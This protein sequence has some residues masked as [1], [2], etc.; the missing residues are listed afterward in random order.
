MA[1]CTVDSVLA[2]RHVDLEVILIDDGSSTPLVV[3]DDPRL[4][5][6][7]HA[8]PRGVSAARNSGIAAANGEWIAFCDDDDVWAPDKLAAQLSAATAIGASWVYAGEVAVDERLRILGGRPPLAPEQV[9]ALLPRFNAVPGSASS[10]MVRADLL[11]HVGDFDPA[12][13]RTEDWDMWLRLARCAAPACVAHPLVAIRQHRANVLIDGDRILRE[14][15]ILAERY[16]IPSDPLAAR[17]RLAWNLF[18]AGQ[19]V[20][21][22]RE[23]VS[24]A[25][26]GDWRSIGR[27]VAAL[28]FTSRGVQR[29]AARI[30]M[31]RDRE[32]IRRANLWLAPLAA[33]CA[34]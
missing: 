18:R 6:I 1:A 13:R 5:A 17:R 19:H 31:R 12:L 24:L 2:Q 7:R 34:A 33:R 3:P 9:L 32:W 29:L 26:A 10:V 16:G 20:A 25:A 30:R 14:P 8:S 4:R 22:A 11:A 28:T 15:A 23:Y 27:A 21:A